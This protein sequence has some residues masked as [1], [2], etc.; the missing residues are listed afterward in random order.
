[1]KELK[2]TLTV[3]DTNTILQ[4]LGQMPFN[5]VYAIIEKINRQANAQLGASEN[6]VDPKKIEAN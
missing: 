2:L 5:Q 3:D 1:M 4:A 6:G